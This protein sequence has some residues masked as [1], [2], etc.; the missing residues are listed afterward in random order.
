MI[1]V[2]LKLEDISD[3]VGTALD[4]HSRAKKLFQEV[5]GGQE[6]KAEIISS[7]RIGTKPEG[8]SNRHLLVAAEG[9][10]DD[11][12]IEIR[13]AP[14]EFADTSDFSLE[15]ANGGLDLNLGNDL[16]LWFRGESA[17][18]FLEGIGEAIQ[19]LLNLEPSISSLPFQ[20][21]EDDTEQE[22]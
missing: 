17:K 6:P 4:P 16:S 12:T 5:A 11:A 22:D 3:D 18:A 19:T 9:E 1:R 2:F 8:L 20:L 21:K 10:A 14:V 7:V 15:L 13:Y